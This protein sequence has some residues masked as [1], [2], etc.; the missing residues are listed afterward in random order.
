MISRP[1]M[2]MPVASK[3]SDGVHLR[4]KESKAHMDSLT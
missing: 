3:T 2:N 1:G 4:A